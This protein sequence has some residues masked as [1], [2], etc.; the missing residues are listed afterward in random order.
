MQTLTTLNFGQNKITA[1]GAQF[2]A[3]SLQNN[4]VR[5]SH[6]FFIPYIYLFHNIDTYYTQSWRK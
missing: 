3:Y 2:I 5:K 4:I 6:Y 1:E